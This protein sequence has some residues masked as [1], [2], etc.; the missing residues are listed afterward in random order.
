MR[1]IIEFTVF[2]VLILVVLIGII[3]A[4]FPSEKSEIEDMS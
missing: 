1:E 3:S 2:V 4:T